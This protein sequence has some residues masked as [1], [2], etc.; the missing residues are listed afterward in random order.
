MD[1]ADGKQDGKWR[2]NEIEPLLGGF[3]TPARVPYQ[4]RV[5]EEIVEREGFGADETPDLLFVNYKMIDYVSH[6]WTVNSPEMRDVVEAQDRALEG[7]VTFLND[8]VGA[9]EW[10]LVLTAD[11]GSV[12]DPQV[13]GAFQISATPISAGI[14]ATFDTNGDDRRIVE[15]I[16]PTQMFID[17]AELARNGHT[18]DELARYV[19]ALTKADVAQPGVVVPAGEADDPVFQAA[20]PASIMDE[21]PCLP[22]AHG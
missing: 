16:Q 8:Q 1:A 12:P 7:F 5:L 3:D 19:M 11:H 6:V 9:G 2:S 21:L 15:L 17:T 13:S 4:T 18:V 22:E 14:N 10:A 20:F